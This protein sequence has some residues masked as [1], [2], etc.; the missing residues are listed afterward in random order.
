MIGDRTELEP[1]MIFCESCIA[2]DAQEG[3]VIECLVAPDR[4]SEL[5]PLRP[6]DLHRRNGEE[7]R[8][9]KIAF[10]ADAGLGNGFLGGDIGQPLLKIGRRKRLDGNKI[11]RAG[12]G[13]LQALGG[14]TRDGPYAG[15]ARGELLPVVGLA[16]AERCHDAHAGDDDN[17]PSEFI[18]WCCHVFPARREH[19]P[20]KRKPVFRKIMLNQKDSAK[21]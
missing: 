9:G 18:A 21:L 20:E 1:V 12:H 8:P 3:V 10:T 19:D 17:R 16:G 4:A 11:D 15:F 5:K 14:K 2:A 7:Q 6:F 13:R